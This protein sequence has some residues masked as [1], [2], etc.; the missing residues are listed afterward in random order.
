M[1]ANV[2]QYVEEGGTRVE[3]IHLRSRTTS[4]SLA[5]LRRWRYVTIDPWPHEGFGGTAPED[6]LVRLTPGGRRSAAVWKPLAATIEDRWRSRFGAGAVADLAVA[7]GAMVERFD[8]P[9]PRYLP[10]VYPTQNGKAAPRL[11]APD[12]T[13]PAP[14]PSDLSARL[15]EVLLGFA[16][17]FEAE[18]RISLTISANTLRVL[19]PSGVRVRDL[20]RATGVSKEGTAMALGFLARHGCAKLGPDP[21]ASRGN[22]V[23]LTAKGEA[24]QAK[25]R[26]ILASTED[27]WRDRFGTGKLAA[28]RLALERVAGS[29]PAG[30]GTLLFEGLEPYP[31]GW[32][33]SI[34]RPEVLPHYPM[35]RHRGGYPDGS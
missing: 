22:I 3:D 5:G 1:W 31:Q 32:R 8:G 13:C 33:S 7:L 24:A 26:R 35:V 30:P 21:T 18:S 27:Q 29:E 12:P 11:L 16:L 28:L 17:D 9:H 19:D 25:Y 10:V 6:S 15:S 14:V 20:P 34:R 2:L 23:R 4:D